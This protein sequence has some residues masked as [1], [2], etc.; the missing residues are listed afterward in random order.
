MGERQL[1]VRPINGGAARNVQVGQMTDG[2]F[3]SEP[4]VIVPCVV[5]K[6]W[7][8]V[9]PTVH[10]AEPGWDLKISLDNFLTRLERPVVA[11]VY[12]EDANGKRF[13]TAFQVSSNNL[14]VEFHQISRTIRLQAPP[15]AP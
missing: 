15:V 2:K 3:T 1:S 6:S 12:H 14:D 13:E 4:S 10:Y 5:E 9:T 8:I 7:A 11:M